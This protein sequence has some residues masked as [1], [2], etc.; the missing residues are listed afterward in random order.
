M[1]EFLQTINTAT[2]G[3]AV[4]L[5]GVSKW[6]NGYQDQP[7]NRFIDIAVKS[8]HTG[9][10]DSLGRRLEI[11]GGTTFP[12]PVVEQY[13]L[14]TENYILDVFVSSTLP[15]SNVISGSNILTPQADIEFHTNLHSFI[16][17]DYTLGKLNDR[18]EL[19]GL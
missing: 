7:T 13:I 6:L 3:T 17:S 11:A 14:K 2:D 8:E 19:Y 10:I 18:K 1:I 9:S 12:S 15:E 16:G 5:G 4:I